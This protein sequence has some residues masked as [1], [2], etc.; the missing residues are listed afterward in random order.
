MIDN[1]DFYEISLNWNNIS[2]TAAQGEV[3]GHRIHYWPIEQN[4]VAINNQIV[5][6]V[7][8][9]EPTRSHKIK[10]LQPYT[11]Y[12]V[13][14]SAFTEGGFGVSSTYKEAGLLQ[15]LMLVITV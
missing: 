5:S 9:F 14:I 8:V 12:G 11:T 10:N 4:D 2:R 7:Y 3:L 1:Y 13:N 15:S 6:T